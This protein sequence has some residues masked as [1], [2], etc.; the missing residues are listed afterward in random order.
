MAKIEISCQYTEPLNLM[1]HRIGLYIYMLKP[2]IYII[3]YRIIGV[4]VNCMLTSSE[5][6]EGFDPRLGDRVQLKTIKLV[7]FA[8]LL[9]TQLWQVRARNQNNMSKGATFLHS[10]YCFSELALKSIS[11]CWSRIQWISSSFHWM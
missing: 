6:D 7:F 10:D 3:Q 11:S 4:M 5:V 8:S 1:Y 2:S 9:S